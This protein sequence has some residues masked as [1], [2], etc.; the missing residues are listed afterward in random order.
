[1]VQVKDLHILISIIL[2][3][4]KIDCH[5]HCHGYRGY[6]IYG[7]YLKGREIG[8]WMRICGDYIEKCYYDETNY[9]LVNLSGHRFD[10]TG[11]VMT[12][13]YN[14][15][16]GKLHGKC[17]IDGSDKYFHQGEEV[18]EEYYKRKVKLSII[19]NI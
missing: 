2:W 15:S 9:Q 1:L 10:R 18:T 3:G 4:H 12:K 17:Y 7:T 8:E 14:Y 13:S 5:L 19:D 16:N 11:E 6:R